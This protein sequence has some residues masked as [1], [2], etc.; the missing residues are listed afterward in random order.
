MRLNHAF[1]SVRFLAVA[2]LLAGACTPPGAGSDGGTDVG[3]TGSDPGD[4]SGGGGG[5]SGGG[6]VDGSSGGGGADSGGGVP[7]QGLPCDV[8]MI[9]AANCRTCHG[10]TPIGN[11]VSMLTLDDMLADSPT[12]ANATI[13]ERSVARMQDTTTPMPPAPTAPVADSDIA[14]IA[15]WVAAGMPP[16]DCNTDPVPSPFDAEPMC[17]SGQM[18]NGGCEE[19][20]RMK[21]GEACIDCHENGGNCGGED[22][23][24]PFFLL[25]GTVYPSGHEPDSCNGFGGAIVSV[26]DAN[27]QTVELDTNEAGNFYLEPNHAPANFD[28]PY[29]VKVVY[30][31]KELPMAMQVTDGD[32]N[33]CHTQDGDQDAPGRIVLPWQ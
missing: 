18:W 23:G 33:K 29:Y 20:S 27:Q 7:G 5:S 10:A 21:P 11:T 28:A 30:D 15:D 22:E 12:V 1:P 25:A 31:G 19:S 24:G 8:D 32:C 6:G 16:G 4:S 3:S 2:G 26:T 14:I 17:S 9:L 13:G